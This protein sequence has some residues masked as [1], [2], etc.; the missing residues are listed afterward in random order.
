M[1]SVFKNPIELNIKLEH[2]DIIF[3]LRNRVDSWILLQSDYFRK[4]LKCFP[5]FCMVAG[6]VVKKKI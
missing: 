1:L 4:E 6:K 5:F 2:V 3:H